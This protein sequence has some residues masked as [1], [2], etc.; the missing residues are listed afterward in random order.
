MERGKEGAREGRID[1][2]RGG[3]E[4]GREGGRGGMDGGREGG[5]KGLNIIDK[6]MLTLDCRIFSELGVGDHGLEQPW[7]AH[8]TGKL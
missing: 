6:Y 7:V 4:E 5:R 3:M 2:G 8:D 1:R